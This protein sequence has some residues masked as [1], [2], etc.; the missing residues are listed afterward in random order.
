MK[1]KVNHFRKYVLV[2]GFILFFVNPNVAFAADTL[3]LMEEIDETACTRSTGKESGTLDKDS[4]TNVEDKVT[5][6]SHSDEISQLLTRHARL[7]TINN[8]I[9]SQQSIQRLSIP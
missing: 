8:I 7:Q 9:R 1:I 6:S 2:L 4:H 5:T 3:A